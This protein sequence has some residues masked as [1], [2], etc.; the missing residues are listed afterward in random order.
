MP[1]ERLHP[2]SALSLIH[3]SLRRSL[4]EGVLCT[5][6]AV[7]HAPPAHA[8]RCLHSDEIGF[9]R[10]KKQ[11]SDCRRALRQQRTQQIAQRPSVVQPI[12]GRADTA[13]GAA[14]GQAG[15]LRGI[16]SLGRPVMAGPVT[17]TYIFRTNRN[18]E[19]KISA[20]WEMCRRRP[21]STPE[22]ALQPGDTRALPIPDL[23]FPHKRT[24]RH[25]APEKK[26]RK[27]TGL[28]SSAPCVGESGPAQTATHGRRPIA[29]DP[30]LSPVCP[31]CLPG[32]VSARGST[33]LHA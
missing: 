11:N 15:A 30:S 5:E 2:S 33:V 7:E 23:L 21:P 31:V 4:C 28:S 18:G 22:K 29:L 3:Y 1:P 16:V 14:L 6:H 8:R 27:K 24:A 13:G 9:W 12:P 26:A 10:R 32:H 25:R 20:A 17:K 19:E